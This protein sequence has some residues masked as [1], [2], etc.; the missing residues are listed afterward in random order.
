VKVKPGARPKNSAV[1]RIAAA[2]N[3]WEAFQVV[4]RADSGSLSG[5]RASVSDFDG[6]ARSTI[7]ASAVSLYRAELIDITQPSGTIGETGRWPDALVPAVDEVDGE[8]RK[9]FPFTVPANES[10]AI[11][12][13]LLVPRDATPGVY[14]GKVAVEADGFRAE[15]PVELEVWNFELPSTPTLETAFL[16]YAGNMCLAHTGSTE[17]GNNLERAKLATKYAQLALDHRISLPNLWVLRPDGDDWSQFDEVFGPLL[18]GTAQTRLPGARLTSAQFN[19]PRTVDNYRKLADHFRDR[20]WFDRLYDYTADEPG[21]GNPWSDIPTRADLIRQADPEIPKLVTTSLPGAT[22]NGVLD[23]IDIIVPA[24]NHMENTVAPYDGDQRPQYD[25]FVASGKRLWMYQSCMSQGCSFGSL[26]PGFDWPSYMIDVSAA[27]NRL[28]G[29]A[30]FKQGV[31]GEL[32]YETV[33]AYGKDP[34]KSQF[35]FNGNGDGTLFYPGTPAKIGGSSG[36]PVASIRLKMIR[37]GIEDYEYL[38]LVSKLGDP[39]MARR[40]AL[41]V[42]PTAYA[43]AG[44]DPEAIMQARER[45]AK[46]ILE[47]GGGE[48]AGGSSKVDFFGDG[49]SAGGCSAAAG[50]PL[51]LLALGLLAFVRRRRP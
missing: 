48:R 5:V 25:D 26:Q 16:I 51:P 28:M 50:A 23:D 43:A 47:L 34:W 17:C 30:N 31:T 44:D 14:R 15:V 10:R 42:L 13:D 29:W 6:P 37:E 12:I 22:E 21:W 1:A 35:D 11:W 3:E 45:L 24:I 39:A 32:Y 18:D 38:A 4:V 41:E 8:Q 2:R 20:G 19:W 40:T 27:R 36:V 7:P 33:N 49:S 9:A 46:R